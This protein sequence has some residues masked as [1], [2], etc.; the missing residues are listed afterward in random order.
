VSQSPPQPSCTIEIAESGRALVLH[1]PGR[2]D[3][4]ISALW[5]RDNDPVDRDS[6]NG[7]KLTN[8]TELPSAPWI[9]AIEGPENQWVTL[10]FAPDG[11]RATFDL[12]ALRSIQATKPATR[13]AWNRDT[14]VK[15]PPSASWPSISNHAGALKSWLGAV[16]DHGLAV[17]SDLPSQENMVTRVAELFGHV[18]ETNYGR[19]FDVRAEADPVNLAYTGLALSVHTD[20]P[21]R[22]PVPSIQLLH[23]LGNE[24]EGG[25]TVLVDGFHAAARLRQDDPSAFETLCRTWVTFVYRSGDT[26]L[27]ARRPMITVDDRGHVIEIRFNNRSLAPLDIPGD[28]MPEFYAA[29]RRFAEILCDPAGELIF[30]LGPGELFA[31]DNRRV[32]HGR[33][34]FSSAGRRH[35]QG[36]Y[37]DMDGLLSRLAVLENGGD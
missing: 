1:E 22:D 31:V 37:A 30:K 36:C 29:Y 27:T 35:L 17:V 20:N 7:Q 5:L 18:R 2:R 10:I 12:G 14:F 26:A 21:Y 6:G 4:R 13:R 25:D 15:G 9:T 24:S 16:R 11:R 3:L 8:I 32:L 34:A 23:C 28:E 33:T 19:V